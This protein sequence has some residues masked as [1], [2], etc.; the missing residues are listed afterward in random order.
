MHKVKTETKSAVFPN[1]LKPAHPCPNDFS[2]LNYVK[3]T[4]QLTRSKYRISVKGS[5][6][7]N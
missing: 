7:W 6:L 1:F 4:S 3:P 5:A 2:K